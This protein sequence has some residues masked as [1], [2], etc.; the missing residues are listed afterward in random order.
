MESF[1]LSFFKRYCL[2]T[3][4]LLASMVSAAAKTKDQVVFDDRFFTER[5]YAELDESPWRERSYP[6]NYLGKGYA[7][8]MYSRSEIAKI[9]RRLFHENLQKRIRQLES[10]HKRKLD[11]SDKD[12]SGILAMGLY[13]PYWKDLELVHE[14][15]GKP[16]PNEV[17]KSYDGVDASQLWL[18]HRHWRNLR[19]NEV[20]GSLRDI[21]KFTDKFS[22]KGGKPGTVHM[23]V[24]G[25]WENMTPE[26][27]ALRVYMRETHSNFTAYF[28]GF[29]K[30]DHKLRY[31]QAK[32]ILSNA[33]GFPLQQRLTAEIF[34]GEIMNKH[35]KTRK[36]DGSLDRH[37][38]VSFWR[39]GNDQPNSTFNLLHDYEVTRNLYR[40]VQIDRIWKGILS[41]KKEEEVRQHI[42]ESHIRDAV[43][44][45]QGTLAGIDRSEETIYL[46]GWN[47]HVEKRLGYVIAALQIH[48]GEN[49]SWEGGYDGF[50]SKAFSEHLKKRGSQIKVL[51]GKEIKPGSI[52]ELLKRLDALIELDAYEKPPPLF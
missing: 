25:R 16:P 13:A 29:L 48:E 36:V 11:V 44:N 49:S 45:L 26:D 5:L 43:L 35:W 37:C 42:K 19:W 39:F 7:N 27:I 18:Y 20:Y 6:G 40:T 30:L 31:A 1:F 38:I 17:P 33:N 10:D 2:L 34:S 3:L 41:E 28:L 52:E 21:A 15:L 50:C 4:C 14:G 47:E 22:Y 24:A 32:D 51:N 12:V 8:R 46:D 9:A 23:I